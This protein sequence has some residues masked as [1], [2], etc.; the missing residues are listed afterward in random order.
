MGGAK[1][2]KGRCDPRERMATVHQ[3]QCPGHPEAARC[4][5]ETKCAT[6]SPKRQRGLLSSFLFFFFLPPPPPSPP[7]ISP[8]LVSSLLDPGFNPSP[9]PPKVLLL[10]LRQT[11]GGVHLSD[12]DEGSARPRSARRAQREEGGGEEEGTGEREMDGQ[13]DGEI[14]R[15]INDR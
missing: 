15:E 7:R 10:V 2:S 11:H 14:A 13:T 4:S 1:G 6:I 5:E 8:L 3:I 12:G 9:Q